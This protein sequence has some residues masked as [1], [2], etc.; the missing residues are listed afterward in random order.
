[1]QKEENSYQ[2]TLGTIQENSMDSPDVSSQEDILDRLEETIESPRQIALYRIQYVNEKGRGLA[3]AFVPLLKAATDAL[4]NKALLQR[5]SPA[6]NDEK[7]RFLLLL[8][9]DSLAHLRRLLQIHLHW[10]RQ[11]PTLAEELGGEGSHAQL[12]RLLLYDHPSSSDSNNL[13]EDEQDAV[14]ELQDLASE[15]ASLTGGTFPLPI[16]HYSLDELRQRLPL[17]FDMAPPAVFDAAVDNDLVGH[18]KTEQIILVHQVT[19]RQS[20]QADVGFVMWP[21][22]VVL[23]RWLFRNHASILRPNDNATSVLEL[24]AGCGLTGL[25]AAR[26]LQQQQQQRTNTKRNNDSHPMVCLT[27]FNPIVLEN[28]RRNVALNNVSCRVVGLDFYQQSGQEC[29]GWKNMENESVREAPVDVILA[30]DIICKPQDAVAAAN[31]IHDA[32][33]PGGRA[34]CVCADAAHRFGVD[35]LSTECKRVG[36]TVQVMDVRELENGQLLLEYNGLD[37]TS[38]YVE[39]MSLTMFFIDKPVR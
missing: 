38:G 8:L 2:G 32:L 21:S 36:L 17:A 14:M 29:M 28:L 1:M 13:S 34:Y 30:A 33:R 25:V 11:D 31:T 3:T 39:S 15:I 24:G 20:E 37:C 27:D 35:R 12:T 9:N 7:S 18:K 6:Q 26:L 10:S 16:S 23:A 19:T 4:L 22:A 5:T